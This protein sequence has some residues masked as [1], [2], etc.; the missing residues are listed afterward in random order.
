MFKVVSTLSIATLIVNIYIWGYQIGYKKNKLYQYYSPSYNEI[1]QHRGTNKIVGL[2]LIEKDLLS[3]ELSQSKD[4]KV[5]SVESSSNFYKSSAKNPEIRLLKGIN[6]YKIGCSNKDLNFSIKIEYTPSD[7]YERA[8]NNIGDSYQLIYSS[9][10][11]DRF[12]RGEISSF[13]ID[14]LLDS[15]KNIVKNIL[16]S[17]ILISKDE[18]SLK[19]VRKIFSFLMDKLYK[20]RGIPNS[21][22]QYLSPYNQYK[23]VVEDG[24]EIW[25]S[26]F[27]TIYN[28]FANCAGVPTRIVSSFGMFD[29]F[30]LSSHAFNESYI[31]ELD[32]WIFVDLHSN[33]IYVRNS[34][35]EPLNSVDLFH[36]V[37]SKS[38][39]SLV[40]DTYQDGNIITTSYPKLN[41]SEVNYLTKDGSLLFLKR[42]FINNK[43]Y[44]R[45]N[46]ALKT[47]LNPNYLYSKNSGGFYYYLTI[48]FF[49]LQIVLA[50]MLLLFWGWKRRR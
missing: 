14:D 40:C 29:G 35:G 48:I 45:V 30:Y 16:K 1:Y 41:S 17:E 32:R 39:D 4:S 8:D 19:K 42:N 31:K 47:V 2:N 43:R 18:T 11:V 27:A 7:I 34:D 36:L 38:Y 21:D 46:E 12:E 49:Y 9:I 24:E 33:K 37:Q 15:E 20:N 50:M 23:T 3:I 28:S 25:C 5:W 6:E 10:P 13:I 26:S 22:I 44:Q